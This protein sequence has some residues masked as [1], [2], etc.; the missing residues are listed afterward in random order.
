MPRNALEV[1][2]ILGLGSLVVAALAAVSPPVRWMLYDTVRHPFSDPSKASS[3][4]DT[5]HRG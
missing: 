4:A 3:G 2:L 1:I 5:A